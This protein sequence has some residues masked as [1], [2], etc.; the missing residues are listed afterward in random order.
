M[1]LFISK[2][3]SDITQLQEIGRSGEHQN[4]N[5]APAYYVN[6]STA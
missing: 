3:R 5:D 2:L 6:D 4:V 1:H